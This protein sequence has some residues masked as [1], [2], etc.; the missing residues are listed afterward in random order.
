MN[1]KYENSGW[2]KS[3]KK[4]ITVQELIEDGKKHLGNSSA[5]QFLEALNN[6]SAKLNEW[7]EDMEKKV[8]NW[9]HTARSNY[10]DTHTHKV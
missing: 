10:Y 9:Y 5:I 1:K 3:D 4:A 7:Y 2:K 6:N 8:N